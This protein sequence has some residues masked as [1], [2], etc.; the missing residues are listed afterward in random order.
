MKSNLLTISAKIALSGVCLFTTM[1]SYAQ[2]QPDVQ[3]AVNNIFTMTEQMKSERLQRQNNALKKIKEAIEALKNGG[4]PQDELKGSAEA[5]EAF[6]YFSKPYLM[7][8][9]ASLQMD[10]PL[11]AH[12]FLIIYD[13][14]AKRSENK[15]MDKQIP[16]S[17]ISQLKSQTNAIV[18][19]YSNDDIEKIAAKANWLDHSLDIGY[20]IGAKVLGSGDNDII[21]A[22]QSSPD[23]GLENHFSVGFSKYLW[24]NKKNAFPTMAAQNYGL[25]LRAGIDYKFDLSNPSYFPSRGQAFVSAGVFLQ[26]W[27]IVPLKVQVNSLNTYSSSI[28]S[29]AYSYTVGSKTSVG[30]YSPIKYDGAPLIMPFTEIRYYT[31]FV[32]GYAHDGLKNKNSAIP[33]ET[34]TYLYVKWNAENYEGLKSSTGDAYS[35]QQAEGLFGFLFTAKRISIGM[36]LGGGVVSASTFKTTGKSVVETVHIDDDFFIGGLQ[37]KYRIFWKHTHTQIF[38]MRPYREH[39]VCK[40]RHCKSSAKAKA[41]ASGP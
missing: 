12:R 35:G 4:N 24:F 28:G 14:L 13:K 18:S 20:D 30:Y 10:K 36:Y 17:F 31:N 37:F 29:F 16:A 25:D 9:Y 5:I 1:L 3:T 22:G 38:V 23:F 19:K 41:N 2:T 39:I 11:D 40:S 33:A 32:S 6:P 27:Y 34:S 21:P 26:R 15:D 7:A 8:A